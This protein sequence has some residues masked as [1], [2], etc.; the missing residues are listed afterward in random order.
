MSSLV[1]PLTQL[2]GV[3]FTLIGIAG[4]ILGDAVWVFEVNTTHNIVHLLTGLLGFGAAMNGKERLYLLTI[5]VVY[6][7]VAAMGFAMDG[8]ILG[9][10]HANDEDNYLHTAV[11]VL[12]ILVGTSKKK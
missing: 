12:G 8:D 10:F 2:F 4:F 6:A 3:V 7:A 5:G 11:A 1:R 9:L